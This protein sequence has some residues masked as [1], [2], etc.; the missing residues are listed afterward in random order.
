MLES[1][2]QQI[3]DEFLGINTIQKLFAGDTTSFNTFLDELPF[4]LWVHDENFRIIHTNRAFNIQFGSCQT[5]RCYQR[6][7]GSQKTCCCCLSKKI[8]GTRQANYCKS[9]KRGHRG[10]DMNIFHIPII[11]DRGEKFI[12]KSSMHFDEYSIESYMLNKYNN[13]SNLVT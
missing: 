8:F 10:Y 4:C 11:N 6:L 1:T 2:S 5:K 9:C 13:D 3:Y 12:V 7:M